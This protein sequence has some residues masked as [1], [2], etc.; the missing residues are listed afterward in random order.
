MTFTVTNTNDDTNPGSL[1]RAVLDAN[2]SPGYDVIDFDASFD[3]A[4]TITLA[5]QLDITEAVAITG[6]GAA[7]TTIQG[8]GSNRLILTQNAP[9]GAAMEALKK[10]RALVLRNP[11]LNRHAP[12]VLSC[13]R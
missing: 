8:G 10:P 3:T 13:T 12:P 9:A 11:P 6:K 1:R 5:T 4:K 2:A 7:L